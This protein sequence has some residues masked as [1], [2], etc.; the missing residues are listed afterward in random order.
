MFPRTKH[1]FHAVRCERDNKKFPSKLER[2]CYDILIS[3]KE[4][5]QIL[6][7]LR[8]VP[9]DLPGGHKHSIDYCVFTPE[10]VIFIEAKGRDLPVGKIK[11]EQVQDIYNINI[12]IVKKANEIYEV[13][14]SNR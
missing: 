7:F 10:N 3:L 13:V 11:R 9:F 14:Q 12:F 2:S 4:K 6:F 1:K 5:K 8:Q